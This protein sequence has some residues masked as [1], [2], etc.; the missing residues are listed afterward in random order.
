MF[1]PWIPT[2]VYYWYEFGR[3]KQQT[4]GIDAQRKAEGYSILSQQTFLD[5]GTIPT[6]QTVW[7]RQG[8][9]TARQ[10]LAA[11]QAP[12]P[13]D[14]A[15]FTIVAGQL[16]TAYAFDFETKNTYSVRVRATQANGSY[17]DRAV[18][19]IVTNVNE[20]PVVAGMATSGLAYSARSGP[21]RLAGSATVSDVDSPVFAGGVLSVAIAAGGLATDQLVVIASGTGPGQIG[22]SGTTITY[23][24][25]AIGSW[26]GGKGT[27]PLTITFNASAT[28]PAVQAL[29]RSIAYASTA[30]DPTA[31]STAPTRSIR[32]TLSDGPAAAGGMT[33][34]VVQTLSVGA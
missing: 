34:T 19:I 25:L 11:L 28:I 12:L 17:Q 16:K 31:A 24:G 3:T 6:Y 13:N 14:N 33:A 5:A 15:A 26:T 7:V 21:I 4:D 20:S 23:G 2:G 18:T 9:A 27:S 29:L 22:V 1:E 32:T 10:D 8:L 30:A